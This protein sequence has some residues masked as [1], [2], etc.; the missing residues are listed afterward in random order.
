MTQI[1]FKDSTINTIGSLPVVGSKAPDFTLTGV[2]LNDVSLA[3]YAGKKVIL[4]IFLSLDTGTCAASVNKFNQIASDKGVTVLCI[5][6]DLPF[7][8]KRFCAAEGIENIVIASDF[9]NNNFG[10]TYGTLMAEGPLEGL[11]SRCIVV[12]NEEGNVVHTEQLSETT[13]VEPDY[14]KALAAL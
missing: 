5:S 11:H 9:K 14:D 2:G 10:E 8:S 1:K 6:K 4:N 3:D 7:A 12:I 13:S